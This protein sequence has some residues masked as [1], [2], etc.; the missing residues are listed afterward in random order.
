MN[1]GKPVILCGPNSTAIPL[2]KY[3]SAALRQPQPIAV[4]IILFAAC[5]NVVVTNYLTGQLVVVLSQNREI[6]G[7]HTTDDTLTMEP[8]VPC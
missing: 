6:F 1:N 7:I 3:S 8:R 4:G 5:V 2:V